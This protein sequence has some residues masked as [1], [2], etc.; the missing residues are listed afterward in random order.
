MKEF[1]P[2]IVITIVGFFGLAA[3]LLIPVW[4]FLNKEEIS[5]EKWD[6]A[7]SEQKASNSQKGPSEQ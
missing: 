5:A 6:E 4:K 1:W 2:V 3:L 7:H